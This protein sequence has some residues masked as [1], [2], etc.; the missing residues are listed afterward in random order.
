LQCRHARAG[1]G[2]DDVRRK[3]DQFCRVFAAVGGI[4]GPTIVDPRVAAG[5]P[6]EL[7]QA[8]K[9]SRWTGFSFPIVPR[10]RPWQPQGPPP[11]LL[12]ARRERPRGSAAEQRDELAPPHSITSSAMERTSPGM[13]RPRALAVLRLISSSNLPDCATGRSAGRAPPKILPL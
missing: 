3:R 8:L 4:R 9:E 12:R 6:S 10:P 11:L 5:G 1:R 7:F 2:Q 13:I